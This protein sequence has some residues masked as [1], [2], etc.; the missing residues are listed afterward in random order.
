MNI[1]FGLLITCIMY[2]L[3]M[4]IYKKFKVSALNPV[5]LSI[6][7]VIV[8]LQVFKIDFK[9][10]NGGGSI[11]TFILGPIVVLLGKP[12]YEN[13]EAI[14]KD[15]FAIFAGVFAGIFTA[16]LSVFTLS[17]VF[18]L[19]TEFANSLYSKSI[20]TPLAVQ[21]TEMFGGIQGITVVAVIATGIFGATIAPSVMRIGR[22]K[23]DVAK[24]I[25]IGTS[26]H[27]VGTSKAIEMGAEI[28]A[29]SGLAMGLTGILTVLGGS[30]FIKL[31]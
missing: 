30:I 3:S 25:G 13:R 18:K 9:F 29:S 8:V 20:T 14:K 7:G 11:I 31:L 24:G 10:Y 2:Y 21:V 6:I 17:K 4:K 26:S 5:L 28:G 15:M 19:D 23:N 22:I 16:V 12:L 1:I 27:G